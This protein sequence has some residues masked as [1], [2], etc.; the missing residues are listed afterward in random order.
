MAV[1]WLEAISENFMGLGGRPRAVL[2]AARRDHPLVL[3]GVSLGIGGVEP[4]SDVYLREWKALI[5][6][7]EPALVS[8]HL[9]FARAHG[10]S[11][12]DL[13]PL[14]LTEEALGHLTSRVQQVQDFLGRQLVLENVS[15]Y[16][17]YRHDELPEWDFVAELARRSGCGLLLD[18]NNV[19]VSAHNHGFSAQAYLDGIPAAAVKY[20]HLAG[21][22]DRG[23]LLL[24]TH[25]GPIPEPVWALYREAVRRFPG[26]PALVEWDEGVP[27]L[28]VVLAEATRAKAEAARVTPKRVA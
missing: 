13:W 20:L 25:Q 19:F 27:A 11:G 10:L 23:A 5:D 7:L 26:V 6:E 2:H 1:D 22:E 17:T 8:D 24:D 16:V 15:S 14:P 3:H 9:C 21:H 12:H 28:E 4:L 18:V